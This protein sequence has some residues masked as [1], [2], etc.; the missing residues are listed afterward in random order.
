[1]DGFRGFD[2]AVT[3]KQVAKMLAATDLVAL[4]G[5]YTSLR[6]QGRRWAGRCPFHRAA[7]TCFSVNPD[8]G[9]YYC[10]G[11]Q[12]SGNAIDFVRGMRQVDGDVAVRILADRAGI[13][14]P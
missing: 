4:V 3:D 6:P 10:F 8:K 14:L 9:V 1:V 13:V 12:V 11:C 5:E 2:V 7:T